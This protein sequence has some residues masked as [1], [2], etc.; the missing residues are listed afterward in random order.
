MT[1]ST[2]PDGGSQTAMAKRIFL[3]VGTPKSG[4]TYLQSLLWSNKTVLKDQGLLLPLGSVREHFFLSNLGRQA[5]DVA[6]MPP[7]ALTAWDRMM[8]EV[9][10]W[11]GDVLISHE[12]FAAAW[13]DRAAWIIDQLR[14][15]GDDVHPLITARDLARQ[16][17]AEWQQSVKHGFTHTLREFYALIRAEDPSVTFWRVQVLPAQVRMWSQGFPPEN[18]HLVTVPPLG[19]PA[20]ALWGRYASV[21]GVDPASVVLPEQ[22]SNVS[23]GLAEVETLRRVN[24]HTPPDTARPLQ[25]R[26]VRDVLGD[27]ILAQRPNASR[28]APPAEEHPW[29]VAHGTAM[30]D[31]LRSMSF[32]VV[33][34]LDDLLPPAEPVVGRVPDD[35]DDSEVAAVAVETISAVLYRSYARQHER[36]DREIERLK[37]AVTAK[38]G[39]ARQLESKLSA[40]WRAYENERRLPL[41]RHTARRARS[42]AKS[43]TSR[44]TG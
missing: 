39:E 9:S 32:D 31:E 42:L 20:H 38:S 26:L 16:V 14:S 2:L 22:Q 35:V 21:I 36:A 24:L 25:Q 28:F 43:I 23:L 13:P 7:R 44:R 40:A 10:G 6:N 4:T 18:L 33:G 37:A 19:G 8:E 15:V 41:W 30:V 34:D 3:H 1:I 27:G 11:P 5:A 12:L 17:P 29:V